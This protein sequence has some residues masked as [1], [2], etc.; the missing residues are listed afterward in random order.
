MAANDGAAGPFISAPSAG[1]RSNDQR[2]QTER[3]LEHRN[4]QRSTGN[5][6]LKS[7]QEKDNNGLIES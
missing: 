4:P 3:F 2:R 1:E 6:D 7:L 5:G